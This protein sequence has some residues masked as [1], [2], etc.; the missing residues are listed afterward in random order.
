MHNKQ[1]LIEQFWNTETVTS[2][3]VFALDLVFAA[4]LGLLLGWVYVR[5]GH[6]LSNRRQFARNF[7]LLTVTTTLVIAIVKSSLALSLGLV[8]ALSIIRFRAAIKEPEELAYLFLAISIGLGLGAGQALLTIAALAVILGL[9]ILHSFFRPT[10]SQ[11][12]LF[13]T[14]TSP[15]PAKVGASQI[16][17][18]LTA[19]GA[20]ASLKR[21]DETPGQVEAAFLVNF[22]NV[23]ALEQFNRRLR[24]LNPDV[25]VSCL[26]DHGLGT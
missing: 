24:E 2:L 3:P 13:L 8:G 19:S 10:P 4:L 14:V 16:L 20:T 5:F 17:Q 15:A 12:N 9:I 1:L 21:F 6:S 25:K 26:D 18:A 23:D 22:K 11:P 7:L